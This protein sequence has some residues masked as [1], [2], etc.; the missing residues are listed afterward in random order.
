MRSSQRTLFIGNPPYV[1]H[2]LIGRRWKN[3]FASTWRRFGIQASQLAGL[4]VHFFLATLMQARPG[5]D[6]AYITAAEWLDVNY[7]ECL[8]KAFLTHLGGEA[9]IRFAPASEP[10]SDAASTAAISLFQVGSK[11]SRIRMREVRQL[12]SLND[13][14]GGRSISRARF[15]CARRWSQLTRI[16]RARSRGLIELGEICRVHRGQ[17]TGANSIWIAGENAENLPARVL[18]PAVTRAREIILAGRI[19]ATAAPL[20]NV[21]DIPADLEELTGGEDFDGRGRAAVERFLRAARKRG[22]HLS[23]LARH[24]RAWW[25]V[26]LR[27]PAPI[28]ATYMARRPP[29]FALNAARA[30]HLNI[31]HGL[32]PREPLT[33]RQLLALVDH[34]SSHVSVADGR[35]Y[36]GGLTKFEPGEME[37]LWVPRP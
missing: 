26:G 3:W 31:A 37:R 34:L 22:A 29:V 4:H 20:R 23:Y 14:S 8:R 1:R 12:A 33:Q 15:E 30:R 7:G 9:L 17:A 13:L 10:F 21:I 25:S 27:A 16:A 32:Y 24:R 2:H 6:G 5:D 36:A 35:T 18:F 19:L 28:L 11:P